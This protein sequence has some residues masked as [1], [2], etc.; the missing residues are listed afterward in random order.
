MNN[1]NV[2]DSIE[3][4]IKLAE[5]WPSLYHE[6]LPR[7]LSADTYGLID[8]HENAAFFMLHHHDLVHFIES[9][10]KLTAALREFM[11][12]LMEDYMSKMPNFD[13]VEFG[14]IFLSTQPMSM[15]DDI[16]RRKEIPVPFHGLQDGVSMRPSQDVPSRWEGVLEGLY[17]SSRSALTHV[18]RLNLVLETL[19][20]GY[21]RDL[22][23]TFDD[24][25]ASTPKRD[26]TICMPS[27]SLLAAALETTRSDL[28]VLRV[29]QK[30]AK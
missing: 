22:A 18:N 28:E 2:I 1:E 21:S 16:M 14:D 11:S 23:E 30:V 29:A 6:H 20:R 15:Q 7:K 5:L 10:Q 24:S 19:G 27:V 3:E 13:P 9:S 12:N 4:R 8:A 26:E 25:G 17:A